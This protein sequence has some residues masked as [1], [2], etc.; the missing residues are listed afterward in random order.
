[1]R[2]EPI[3]ALGLVAALVGCDA[4]PPSGVPFVPPDGGQAPLAEGA[5]RHLNGGAF[6]DR[7]CSGDWQCCE[8]A[9][10]F[11]DS[12]DAD[13]GACGACACEDESGA[14]GCAPAVDAGPPRFDGGGSASPRDAGAPPQVD[15]GVDAGMTTPPTD[16]GE[17][18]VHSF[19]GR[20]AHLGCSASYQ[21]C[22]GLWRAQR[23]G[24]GS[25]LCVEESGE[26][27]CDA[28]G[29]LEPPADPPAPGPSTSESVD[30]PQGGS[31][32]GGVRVSEH[33]LYHVFTGRQANY[34][35]QETVAAIVA[36]FD[37]VRARHPAVGA[38]EVRDISIQHGGRRSG[39][40]PHGS[41]QSG[42]DVD[43]TYWRSGGCSGYCGL[44]DVSASTLD[45]PPTW[46]LLESFLRE[47]RMRMVF[48]DQSLHGVLR[49][50][51]E[52]RG[53]SRSQLDA[54]FTKIQHWPNHINHMHVRFECPT[55]DARCRD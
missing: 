49:A 27:G 37:A 30:R 13:F 26:R 36:A 45:A 55:D 22:D 24:C 14:F 6:V 41:H 8:G 9:W 33:P 29:V 19:G 18:C 28:G 34:G 5:C 52:S 54:W 20:Y 31:L 4:S 48:I 39:E 53:H 21:C 2:S 44:R 35:T 43:I 25:C 47:G 51:A 1:M 38:A 32:E 23:A 17:A 42:R 10:R 11:E 46:T 16:E 15:A 12:G 7:G 3:W 50:E 40:W